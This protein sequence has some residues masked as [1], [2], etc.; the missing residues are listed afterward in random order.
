MKAMDAIIKGLAT[1]QDKAASLED[2][3]TYALVQKIVRDVS[4]INFSYCDLDLS[5]D[6]VEQATK[7]IAPT[8]E[9]DVKE[10]KPDTVTTT[11]K[12]KTRVDI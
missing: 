10:T 7:E 9:V 11:S 8:A 3:N 1:I 6:H 5:Q 4:S 2:G 12:L